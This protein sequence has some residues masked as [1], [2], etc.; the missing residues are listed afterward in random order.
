MT[1]TP[2]PETAMDRLNKFGEEI[3]AARSAVNAAHEVVSPRSNATERRTLAA[4][5]SHLAD[6][7]K[8]AS[9]DVCVL[10]GGDL[11]STV[12]IDAESGAKTDARDWNELADSAAARE[13]RDANPKTDNAS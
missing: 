4:A 2:A 13:A 12:L 1:G 9:A 5:Y 3:R 10:P 8:R 7:Y 6:V 11:L